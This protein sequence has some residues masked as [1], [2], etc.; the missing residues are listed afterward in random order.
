MLVS[1]KKLRMG[2]A[3]LYWMLRPRA[4]EEPLLKPKMLRRWRGT[5]ALVAGSGA[6]Y[7]E[8]ATYEAHAIVEQ[9]PRRST[10]YVSPY[11][12]ALV[13][14]QLGDTE[15]VAGVLEKRFAS[16]P[17]GRMLAASRNAIC[18]PDSRFSELLQRTKNL[19]ARTC[20]RNTVVE[21]RRPSPLTGSLTVEAS[22]TARLSRSRPRRCSIMRLSKLIVSSWPRVVCCVIRAGCRPSPRGADLVLTTRCGNS[23]RGDSIRHRSLL[24]CARHDALA[25]V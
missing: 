8:A 25:Q 2:T 15:T 10:R 4:Y 13:Y 24:A 3:H 21:N 11:M 7:A 1:L 5:S 9:L 18:S 16:A 12:L 23:A 17:H 22:G 19:R 6:A 20:G 14:C